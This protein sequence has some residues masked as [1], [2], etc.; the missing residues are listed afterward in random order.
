M[1]KPIP[2]PPR[3]RVTVK[4]QSVQTHEAFVD[5]M[6]H[7]TIGHM[8]DNFLADE[9]SAGRTPNKLTL[10]LNPPEELNPADVDDV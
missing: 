6:G 4:I 9:Q 1:A 3:K 5:P 10:N 2:E 8:I 7:E